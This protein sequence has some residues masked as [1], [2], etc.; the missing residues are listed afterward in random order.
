MNRGA[1]RD[2]FNQVESVSNAI[3]YLSMIL[4]ENRFALFGLM[5]YVQLRLRAD[6]S[7]VVQPSRSI[8]RSKVSPCV[9]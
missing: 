3:F 4:S 2:G 5:L 1:F 6:K 7:I 8:R 9:R